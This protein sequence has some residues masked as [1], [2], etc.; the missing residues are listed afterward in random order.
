MAHEILELNIF[1][2]DILEENYLKYYKL[3]QIPDEKKT[4]DDWDNILRLLVYGQFCSVI[5]QDFI[6]IYRYKTT[7]WY[8]YVIDD[9]NEFLRDGSTF[10]E[11]S[12]NWYD[13]GT[14]KEA[15]TSKIKDD[16]IQMAEYMKESYEIYYMPWEKM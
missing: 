7:C 3:Q 1:Q 9:Y 8:E 11:W 12:N 10:E 16:I 4:Y 5:T 13:L 2:E 15:L 6:E 14:I